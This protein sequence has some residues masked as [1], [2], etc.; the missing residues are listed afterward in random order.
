MRTKLIL[1]TA[2]FGV[3]SLGAF[4]QVYSVNA[5][6]YINKTVPA[7]GLAILAN[8]LNSGGNAIVDVITNPVEGLLVYKYSQA[9]GFAGNG[10]TFGEWEVPAMVLAPGEAFFV[11]NPTA[12]AVTLT[13]VGEVP[14]GALSTTLAQGLNLV[15]SQVPQAG[16]IAS[17]L[18][19]VPSEGDIVY[20]WTG[21]GYAG[22]GYTFGEWE[23]AQPELAVGEGVFISR[24]TAG[25]W[26]RTFSVNQ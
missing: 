21:T 20:K 14:Q 6:G 11:S 4:A 23:G 12:A 25:A 5:V 24:G 1:T 10:Y 15:A 17:V 9:G 19:Y 16:A 18:G 8:Q 3:A 26:T 22:T 7:N 13:F 2:V